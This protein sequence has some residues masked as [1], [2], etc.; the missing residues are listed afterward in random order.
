MSI[1]AASEFARDL[2]FNKTWIENLSLA[3]HQMLEYPV[4]ASRLLLLAF[5]RNEEWSPKYCCMHLLLDAPTRRMPWDWWDASGKPSRKTFLVGWAF[6]DALS[7]PLKFSSVLP[8]HHLHTASFTKLILCCPADLF[9]SDEILYPLSSGRSYTITW[10]TF[11]H[12][13]SL[14]HTSSQNKLA[15]HRNLL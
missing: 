4:W 3:S 6:L 11:L 5:P 8:D 12:W 13:S 9:P 14:I 15:L 1:M 10:Q 7:D 2:K